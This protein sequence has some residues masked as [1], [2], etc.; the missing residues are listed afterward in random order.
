[1]RALNEYGVRLNSFV[2]KGSGNSDSMWN[3][4]VSVMLKNLEETEL[5]HR[6]RC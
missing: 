6:I 3:K 5:T 1:M 2:N 4:N